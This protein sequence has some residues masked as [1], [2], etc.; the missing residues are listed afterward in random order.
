MTDSQKFS[1]SNQKWVDWFDKPY[2]RRIG[3]TKFVTKI[4]FFT[5]FRL[6]EN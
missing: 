5:R 2:L 1:E 4:G 3:V 6:D